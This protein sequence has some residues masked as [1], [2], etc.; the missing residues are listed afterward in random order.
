MWRKVSSKVTPILGL[1]EHCETPSMT[2][3]TGSSA[4]MMLV[5]ML[6]K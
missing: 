4:V 5:L 1:I 3:S 6:F 2:Y